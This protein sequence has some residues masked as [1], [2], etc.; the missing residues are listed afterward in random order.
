MRGGA[1]F[2][3]NVGMRVS[4]AFL[5][6]FMI[7]N[8]PKNPKFSSLAPSALASHLYTSLAGGA[9]KQS[10]RE[11]VRLVLYYFGPSIAVLVVAFRAL[12]RTSGSSTTPHFIF[13]RGQ[14]VQKRA[15]SQTPCVNYYLRWP[16][17]DLELFTE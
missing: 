9:Q 6:V 3:E 7:A 1:N 15:Q 2:F 16:N 4:G 13:L 17:R 8:N 12:M 11:S 10:I 14:T 5:G